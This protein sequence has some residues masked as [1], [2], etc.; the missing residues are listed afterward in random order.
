MKALKNRT[1]ESPAQISWQQIL[2]S[3]ED[4]V[5]TLDPNGKVVFFNE[6]A[7]VLTETSAAQALQGDLE[8]VFRHEPWLSD[9]VNKSRPPRQESARGEGDLLTRRGRKLPVN[10]TVSPLTDQQGNFIGRFAI[11]SAA[12]E[13]RRNSCGAASSP[14][15]RCGNTPTSWFA[16]SIALTN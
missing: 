2:G 10:V 12:S 3:L 9:L 7:E 14:T 6:A 1:P 11:P 5:V 4:G 8:G 13:A 16:R 15:P